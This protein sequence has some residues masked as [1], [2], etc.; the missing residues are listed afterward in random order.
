MN[1]WISVVV[2]LVIVMAV[3]LLRERWRVSGIESLAKSKGLTPLFPVPSGGPQPAASLVALLTIHGGRLWGTVLTGTIDG[4]PVTIAEHESSE[5]GKKTGVWS[6]VVSW[7]VAGV[8]GRLVLHR[9]RGNAALANAAAVLVEPVRAAVGLPA[10]PGQNETET[11][12]GWTVTGEPID[13]DRWLTPDR[14]RALDAWE[15]EASFAREG[16]FAAWRFREMITVERLT[17][18]IDQFPTVRRLLE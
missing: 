17:Q 3:A 9:G 8:K 7:P 14:V 10:R 18:I 13:R 2:L 4:V 16:G 5:Q 6:T 12:G 11:P 1:N 15:P